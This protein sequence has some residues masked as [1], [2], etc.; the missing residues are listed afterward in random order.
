MKL[1]N[2]DKDVKIFKKMIFFLRIRLNSLTD[3]IK[4]TTVSKKQT[5]TYTTKTTLH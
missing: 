1:N 3:T 2:G 4:T 5:T